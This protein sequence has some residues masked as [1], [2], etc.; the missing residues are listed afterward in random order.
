MALAWFIGTDVAL[1]SGFFAL[2]AAAG[3][4]LG[5]AL[6]VVR[7]RAIRRSKRSDPIAR[8]QAGMGPPQA[9]GAASRA[10]STR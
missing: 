5:W 1:L 10:R 8:P 7:S 3:L 2:S 6:K 4:W 9:I